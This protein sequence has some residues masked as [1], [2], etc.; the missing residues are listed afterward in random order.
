MDKN[1]DLITLFKNNFMLRRPRIANFDII[2][3]A[4]K[5]KTQSISAFL[6]I[7]K[8]LFLGEKILMSAELKACVM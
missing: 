1:Y 4:T 5:V 6:D 7:K 2:K 3:I 8:L